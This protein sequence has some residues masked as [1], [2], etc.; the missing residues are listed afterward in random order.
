MFLGFSSKH[1]STVGLIL[2]IATGH[3]SPQYHVVHDEKF[4][5]VTSTRLQVEAMKVDRGTFTL[6]DCND[7]VVCGYDRLPALSDAVENRGPLPT[8]G[9]EWKLPA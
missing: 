5:T 2:N 8:L 3:V 9:V 1:S 6:E 7:L 4:S